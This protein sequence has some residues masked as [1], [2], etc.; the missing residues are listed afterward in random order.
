MIINRVAVGSMNTSDATV[1]EKD[2][3]NGE[4]ICNSEGLITGTAPFEYIG[5]EGE[6]DNYKILQD[7]M[8][9][10]LPNG[11]K[12][13]LKFG[14]VIN[15]NNWTFVE[16]PF[17]GDLCY[18][19]GKF[20]KINANGNAAAYSTDG[21]TWTQVLLPISSQWYSVC[22]GNGKFVAV[23]FRKSI[24]VYSTDGIT[25]TQTSL[26]CSADWYSVCYGKDKFVATSINGYYK[27]VYSTDGITW[28]QTSL[29]SSSNDW[30]TVC[31]G[32][33][34]FVAIGETEIT[35][36]TNGITWTQTI[37]LPTDTTDLWIAVCY[38]NGKFVAT[39]RGNG[40]VY[41]TDGITW[42]QSNIGSSHLW[43]KIC[44]GNGQFVAVCQNS[45]ATPIAYSTNSIN[46]NVICYNN[47][48]CHG[49]CYG[50]NKFVTSNNY[51]IY[52]KDDY[53]TQFTLKAV[54][55][56]KKIYKM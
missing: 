56:A 16:G 54:I 13:L 17:T 55:F 23:A 21:I 35:Y 48:S 24:A 9:I 22:Y 18:G 45:S 20:V 4:T 2:V 12:K 27:S 51:G 8:Y 15:D 33:D 7:E 39:G 1:T 42:Y 46:W 25:W 44:Y 19:N 10:L 50:N 6:I 26:P 53:I 31:Y 28:T 43:S 37:S 11:E 52:Y 49:L 41:S 47:G 40:A 38:G 34:K 14:D 5:T 30:R 36:S 29:P 3:M 32:K